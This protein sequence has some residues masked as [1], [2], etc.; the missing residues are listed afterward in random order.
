[1]PDFD[2]SL[3]EVCHSVLLEVFGPGGRDATSWWLAKSDV[4]LSDCARKPQE[5]DDALSELFQPT[6]ALVIEAR[7]L[8]RFYR[9]LG[10]RYER[11]STLIFADEVRRAKELFDRKNPR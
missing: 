5:F 3:N 7:I 6:G 2:N 4:S 8:A 10:A 11:G 9:N 1:M